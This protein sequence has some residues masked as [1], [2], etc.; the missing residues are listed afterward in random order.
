M[1]VPVSQCIPPPSPTLSP[2]NHKFIFYIHD[3]TSVLELIYLEF[4]IYYLTHGLAECL[5]Q[6]R[7]SVYLSI[8]L[9]NEGMNKNEDLQFL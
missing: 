5:E 1:S 4:L 6:S 3:S 7:N 9:I 8:N 2:G